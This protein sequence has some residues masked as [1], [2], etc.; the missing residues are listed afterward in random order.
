MYINGKWLEDP[1]IIAYIAELKDEIKLL[2]EALSKHSE[3][4][5]D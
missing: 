2:R 5:Y 1:E 3:E 4:E